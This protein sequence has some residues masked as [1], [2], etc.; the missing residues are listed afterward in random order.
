M[1][2]YVC[3]VLV[4]ASLLLGQS[5][6]GNITGVVTDASGSAIANVPVTIVNTATNSTE[7]VTTTNTGEYNAPNLTPGT[8]RVEVSAP[9]FRG[10]VQNN[11]VLTAGATVRSDAQLQIGKLTEVIEVQAQAAQMQTEDAKISSAVQN[12]LVDELPLVVGGALRSPFDLVSTVA[13]AKG[14]GTTLSLGGGQAAGWSA[15][16]DGLSVNTN[17]SAD[18]AETAYL[19]PSVEA[20]TE[21]AVDT[22]GFKAEFGQAAGGV[23]TFVSKSGTNDYHGTAYE[24]LR[25]DDF[26]ARNFFAASRSIYK[27]SDFGASVGGPVSIPKLYHGKNRTFFFASYEG[28]RNRLGAQRKRIECSHARN[29]PGEFFE[30]GE[31]QRRPDSDLRPEQHAREPEWQR[32]YSRSVSGQHHSRF[33]IQQGGAADYSVCE[34]RCAKQARHCAGDAGMGWKQLRHQ[35]RRYHQ[36]HG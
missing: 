18:T 8:Y 31:F 30:L 12:K 10:A 32:L 16:L 11:I 35:R 25:N 17:R 36:P 20:I 21:F 23:I 29:V 27:Q 2:R 28:F 34:K 7:R 26:D 1:N 4:A 24:F 6:R 5:E 33:A 22:G 3:V 19:T 9:G 13:E 14:S 15:T